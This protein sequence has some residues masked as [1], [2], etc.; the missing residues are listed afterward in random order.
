M[1]SESIS[2]VKKALAGFPGLADVTVIEHGAG[3]ADECLIAYVVPS[4]RSVEAMLLAGR[5]NA[6]LDT[7]ISMADLF[8]APT[9][10][11]LDRHLDQM[12]STP[13]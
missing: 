10:A 9:V 6:D 1:D 8:R 3:Q 13:K 11:D 7:R 5:I 12:A 2:D 4:G